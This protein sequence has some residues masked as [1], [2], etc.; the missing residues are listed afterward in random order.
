MKKLLSLIL[1]LAL[2]CSFAVVPANAASQEAIDAAEKLHEYGLLNGMGNN[3]DGSINYALDNVVT[4]GVAV[5]MLVRLLGKEDIAKS[6]TWSTP[7]VDVPIW[8][9]PYVG[10]AYANNLTGGT[11][12]NT[13]SNDVPATVSQYLTFV[14]RALG[15]SSSTDF[16]WDKAWELSDQLGIT[17][18]QFNTSS[19]ALTRGDMA[20]ISLLA[21]SAKLK[22]T[23]RTLADSL[24]IDLNA[25]AS[26]K[27]EKVALID[28]NYGF[29]R[30]NGKLYQF[31]NSESHK[32][33]GH[34]LNLYVQNDKNNSDV[35]LNVC[36]NEY[37]SFLV[38]F[39]A[40]LTHSY[41]TIT[42]EN[43][44][45][46]GGIN[47]D[48]TTFSSDTIKVTRETKY[49]SAADVE[50]VWTHSYRGKTLTIPADISKGKNMFDTTIIDGI[51]Y[52]GKYANVTD[53]CDYFG[54]TL[55]IRDEYDS[56]VQQHIL[57]IDY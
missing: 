14:L 26:P 42:P 17:N 3:P 23:D 21:L 38:P 35:Y 11:G 4:R 41:K 24:G 16:Q 54:L 48:E 57:V 9:E 55:S 28:A 53:Y 5:A 36:D 50:Y 2:L 29:A 30:I 51:K 45:V 43:P 22:N 37:P 19:P 12:N 52:C 1:S 39:L 47:M 56:K 25:S 31:I 27:V 49:V 34:I 44:F 15:Y 20:I 8:A 18:G 40:L 33:Q 32:S 10:Y 13:F 7:F 46:D 6:K